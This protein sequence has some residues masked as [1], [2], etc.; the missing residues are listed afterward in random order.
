MG[1]TVSDFE[2]QVIPF[3]APEYRDSARLVKRLTDELNLPQLFALQD[4]LAVRYKRKVGLSDIASVNKFLVTHGMAG[5][6][7]E[8]GLTEDT[9]RK[10]IADVIR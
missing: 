1:S 6:V 4:K 8:L 2:A 10:V 7:G 5:T 3:I 9:L